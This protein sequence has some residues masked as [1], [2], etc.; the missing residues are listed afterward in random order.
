MMRARPELQHA[1]SNMVNLAPGDKDD[2]V[3]QFDKPG[4]FDFA[5]LGPDHLEPGM[6]GKIEVTGVSEPVFVTEQLGW[7]KP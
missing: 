5:G 3:W 1:D 7:K 2:V 6:T 4:K